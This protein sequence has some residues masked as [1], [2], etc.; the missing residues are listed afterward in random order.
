MQIQTI[1]VQEL[2]RQIADGAL[3]RGAIIL[4]VRTDV[5]CKECSVLPAVNI[6]VSKLKGDEEVLKKASKI[7]IMCKAGVRA[8]KAYQKMP[9]EI[10]QKAF[11]VTGG[12]DFWLLNG[13]EVVRGQIP[14]RPL[15]QQMQLTVGV[16]AIIGSVLA[17]FVSKW[18][19]VVPL[20]LGCGLTFAGLTGICLLLRVLAKMPW[21]R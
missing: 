6:E 13:Y 16:L 9:E 14:R 20:L 21:N 10:A 1:A 17:L 8:T 18:F 15:I 12:M 11:V 3:E 7:Y 5:E 2:H 19:A 4:D